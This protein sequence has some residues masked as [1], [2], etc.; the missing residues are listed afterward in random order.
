LS[1]KKKGILQKRK[2]GGGQA[3]EK[4]PQPKHGNIVKK[5]DRKGGGRTENQRGQAFKKSV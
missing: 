2:R 1:G 5:V 3:K 4:S